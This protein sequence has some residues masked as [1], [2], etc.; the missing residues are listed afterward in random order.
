MVALFS[1]FHPWKKRKDYEQAYGGAG[2][3]DGET[4]PY[5]DAEYFRTRYPNFN[6]YEIIWGDTITA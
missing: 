2:K 5:Q 3:D 4:T 6:L 1:S